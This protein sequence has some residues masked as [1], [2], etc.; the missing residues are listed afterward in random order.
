MDCYGCRFVLLIFLIVMV[1]DYIVMV[2]VGS[3]W[4]L[5]VGWIVGGIIVVIYFIVSVYMVDILILD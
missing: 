2:L 1:F 4:F 3:I 5:L